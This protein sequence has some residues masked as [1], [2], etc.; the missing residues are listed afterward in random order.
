MAHYDDFRGNAEPPLD[1]EK[2]RQQLRT[3]QTP[4]RVRELHQDFWKRE[5]S[6]QIDQES[7]QFVREDALDASLV[8]TLLNRCPKHLLSNPHLGQETLQQARKYIF[9]GIQH[10]AIGAP[11]KLLGFLVL[12]R[13]HV[14][15]E[16]A[17]EQLKPRIWDRGDH[18]NG[19]ITLYEKGLE[20][21]WTQQRFQEE[22]EK[23]LSESGP[24][25]AAAGVYARHPD[26]PV[27][28]ILR[29]YHLSGTDQMIEILWKRTNLDSFSQTEK[30]EPHPEIL[31]HPQVQN[32]L[33]TWIREVRE[34]EDSVYGVPRPWRGLTDYLLTHPRPEIIP[35][36]ELVALKLNNG[37]S[38][39][40]LPE[41]L[42]RKLTNPEVAQRYAR[43]GTDCFSYLLSHPD[44]EVRQTALR[45]AQK[46]EQ[47]NNSG[48]KPLF[49]SDSPQGKTTKRKGR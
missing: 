29:L 25:V 49:P 38:P 24:L 28:E 11:E 3:A 44:P 22:L 47:Q 27:K 20:K 9:L 31:D 21:N 12:R 37:Q 13:A 6:E 45:A 14:L 2:L 35:P 5:K 4:E 34:Q 18:L 7:G 41:M 46:I 8:R 23:H 26:T 1:R 15:T 39:E 43:T 19:Y 17:V 10:G 30:K 40:A 16:E 42:K 32:T 48:R 36:Q 33:S